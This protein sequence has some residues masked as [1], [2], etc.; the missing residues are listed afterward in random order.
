MDVFGT[1]ANLI[2]ALGKT[3]F[4][5]LWIGFLILALLRM[6]LL[7]IPERHSNQRYLLSVASMLVLAGTVLTT[8]ILLYVPGS[9]PASGLR[10]WELHRIIPQF[11]AMDYSS[12]S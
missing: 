1:S 8:F 10:I 7:A 12:S 5:S 4:H 11:L 6:L 9:L 3:I 2:V